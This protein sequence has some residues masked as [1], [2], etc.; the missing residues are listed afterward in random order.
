M[1][2]DAFE[3]LEELRY[4]RAKLDAAEQGLLNGVPSYSLDQVFDEVEDI[5]SADEKI[6]A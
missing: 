6:Q 3:R 2:I 5:Y 1:S 4:L